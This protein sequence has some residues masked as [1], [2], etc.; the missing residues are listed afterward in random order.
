MN[1]AL[2]SLLKGAGIGDI[3]IPK[4]D[5]I[6]EHKHIVGLLRKYDIP[7]LKA[8]ANKQAK[9]LKAETGVDLTGSGITHRMSV[10][11]KYK[12][13]DKPYSI[14]ELSKISKIPESILQEVYNRG[15]GA[16]STSKKSVR[17]KHSFVKNVDA[18]MSAKLS[19]EQWGMARVYS[20]LDGNPS[21]DEDLRRNKGGFSKQSGFIRRLMAEN[22]VKHQGQ[23]KKPTW[24]L[25]KD[26][27]MNEPAE[28]DYTRIANEDQRGE[29]PNEYGASPFIQKHFG[30]S[31]A[32]PFV[33]KR[34]IA[35]PLEPYEKERVRK[36]KT[37]ETT[38]Q[39]IA[40]KNWVVP[41]PPEDNV[42]TTDTID[43]KGQPEVPNVPLNVEVPIP[44]PP[45][46][47]KLTKAEKKEQER[48]AAEEQR[49]R[50][51]EMRRPKISK[52]LEER[53][54]EYAK[55]P[56]NHG[57]TPLQLAEQFDWKEVN[58]AMLR[59]EGI[60]P[61]DR[62]KDWMSS[63][64]YKFRNM[65]IKWIEM[66]AEDDPNFI[67]SV[68]FDAIP[69]VSES[70]GRWNWTPKQLDSADYQAWFYNKDRFRQ[71]GPPRDY[72]D[73]VSMIPRLLSNIR[74]SLNEV[75]PKSKP[76]VPDKAIIYL[77]QNKYGFR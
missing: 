3:L 26:S 7:E 22:R 37:Q 70:E 40:R 46:V 8:E 77:L 59:H 14:T 1:D 49:K 33:R 35:P 66:K 69:K 23:Y 55:K 11:K 50:D 76:P 52:E 17:L 72:S 62:K 45:K 44:K 19:K 20:F 30:F 38:E 43:D 2:V 68:A 74:W 41:E 34:G 64:Y 71:Y 36:E 42:I 16:H 73:K 48:I 21:H 67:P 29:N 56:S 57:L 4:K 32:V 39:K 47:K 54:T 25:H 6:Q 12:L 61:G 53:L 75:E 27:T 58:E 24:P 18:P 65:L 9:E 60:E 63:G 51:R 15:V 10:L 13:D 5:F 28:F 31:R